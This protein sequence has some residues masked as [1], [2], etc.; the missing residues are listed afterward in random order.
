MSYRFI[1][2]GRVQ[3]MGKFRSFIKR[4]PEQ[5]MSSST[6]RYFPG[7]ELYGIAFSYQDENMSCTSLPLLWND[8]YPS[9]IHLVK[10]TVSQ[11]H[12]VPDCY[13]ERK[14][15]ELSCD[16]YHL[17]GT[18]GRTYTNQFPTASYGQL[19]DTADRIFTEEVAEGGWKERLERDAEDPSR[20]MLVTSVFAD[21][22]KGI[23]DIRR[24]MKEIHQPKKHS[25]TIQY[26]E[27]QRKLN[28]LEKLQED[29]R[30][31]VLK[32]FEVCIYAKARFRGSFFEGKIAKDQHE[33][34]GDLFVPVHSKHALIAAFKKVKRYVVDHR[35]RCLPGF[36]TR[37]Y[38]D[39][40]NGQIHMEGNFIGGFQSRK[41]KKRGRHSKS[42]WSTQHKGRYRQYFTESGFRR[43]LRQGFGCF[44]TDMAR[45]SVLLAHSADVEEFKRVLAATDA[46]GF[47]LGVLFKGIPDTKEA[48]V[49]YMIDQAQ[50]R[51]LEEMSRQMDRDYPDHYQPEVDE[52]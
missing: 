16:G 23:R 44:I 28:Q 15:P 30:H 14:P 18:N 46:T 34:W 37:L 24:K 39:H 50:N 7:Q 33:A 32:Q 48:F 13:D 4:P 19:T 41:E 9:K 3:P 1:P 31:E 35:E 47:E 26:Y 17:V 38:G 25:Q 43:S 40:E 22:T 2:P 29:I 42:A 51:A 6:G 5:G 8:K 20:Y 12:K 52:E 21:V 11:H 27:F 45:S 49:S 10:L 36:Y